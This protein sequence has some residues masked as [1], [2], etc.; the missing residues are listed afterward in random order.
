MFVEMQPGIDPEAVP[1]VGGEAL[2]GN[3]LLAENAGSAFTLP[4]VVYHLIPVILF[5]S[6]GFIAARWVEA[7]TLSKGILTGLSL[8]VGAHLPAIVGTLVFSTA[9]GGPEFWHTLGLAGIAFPAVCGIVGGMLAVLY[10]R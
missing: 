7:T 9:A 5:I 4:T 1:T 3:V 2:Q 10:T 6:G 8:P